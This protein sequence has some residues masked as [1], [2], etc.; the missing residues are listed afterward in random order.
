MNIVEKR[1]AERGLTKAQFCKTA[2]V[3]LSALNRLIQGKNIRFETLIKLSKTLG[4]SP[5]Q[6][7]DG[8][9]PD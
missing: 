4:I 3:S 2:H 8:F 6:I 1:L 7:S 9:Y 5:T